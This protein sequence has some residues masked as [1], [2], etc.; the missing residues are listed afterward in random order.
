M[1][2]PE[3]LAG[4]QMEAFT[5]APDSNYDIGGNDARDVEEC[6]ADYIRDRIVEA[7]EADRAQRDLVALIA[8]TLDDRGATDA[9]DLV[10]DTDPDD[11]LWN[12]YIG[13]MLDS[14]ED[15]Y[16]GMAKEINA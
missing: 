15:D 6:S 2:T 9:A 3:Q 8:E 12:N 7:I 1:K 4:E 16:T 10:R 5:I 13:P 14:I 11:D